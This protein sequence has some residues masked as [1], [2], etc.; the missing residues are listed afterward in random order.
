MAGTRRGDHADHVLAQLI[1]RF[2]KFL[3]IQRV[4]PPNGL[5]LAYSAK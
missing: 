5:I 2:F 1:G 3:D 4:L